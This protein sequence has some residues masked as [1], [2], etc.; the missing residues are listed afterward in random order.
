MLSLQF[1]KF[2][3]KAFSLVKV[4][5]FFGEKIKHKPLIANLFNL[6]SCVIVYFEKFKLAQTE[7]NLVSRPVQFFVPTVNCLI[8]PS[9]LQNCS[10]FLAGTDLH[11]CLLQTSVIRYL[12]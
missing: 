9:T 10:P 6:L 11:F 8:W 1:A 4:V 5:V 2:K 3:F 7:I 12:H